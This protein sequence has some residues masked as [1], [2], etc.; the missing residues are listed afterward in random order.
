MWIFF[1]DLGPDQL[2]AVCS[3]KNKASSQQRG[4]TDRLEAWRQ[5]WS[6]QRTEETER[7][8]GTHASLC[9][10][11]RARGTKAASLVVQGCREGCKGS[12]DVAAVQCRM[13]GT[14]KQGAKESPSL[15]FL[16]DSQSLWDRVLSM[17]VC[18]LEKPQLLWMKQKMETVHSWWLQRFTEACLACCSASS[19]LQ[20]PHDIQPINMTGPQKLQ[21][22]RD[23]LVG[24]SFWEEREEIKCQQESSHWNRQRDRQSFDKDTTKQ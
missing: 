17:G 19:P 11:D 4:D 20:S 13:E 14:G 22:T 10:W 9:T 6:Q 21:T 7:A 3:C 16:A 8:R 2:E 5:L 15:I 23:I 12:R 24:K 1:C 18:L